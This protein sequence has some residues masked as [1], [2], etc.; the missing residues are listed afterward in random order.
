MTNYFKFTY[1]FIV[2]IFFS[3]LLNFSLQAEIKIINTKQSTKVIKLNNGKTNTCK[4]AQ[5]KIGKLKNKKISLLPDLYYNKSTK[6]FCISSKNKSSRILKTK[7]L[8]KNLSLN[9][10]N[11][12]GMLLTGSN[13]LNTILAYF[14][15]LAGYTTKLSLQELIEIYATLSRTSLDENKAVYTEILRIL[16]SLL[17]LS[18]PTPTPNSCPTAPRCTGNKHLNTSTCECACAAC[19]DG[20][21]PNDDSC[22]CS[23][24]PII[25]Y[26]P[27]PSCAVCTIAGCE[28]I[29]E[30]KY[31]EMCCDGG[32][33]THG[34]IQSF[35]GQHFADTDNDGTNDWSCGQFSRSCFSCSNNT[36]RCG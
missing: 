8:A 2:T 18:A 5:I 7:Y 17:A 33:C 24:P 36:R 28:N 3:I 12:R 10:R 34:D 29:M 31:E 15:E 32:N 35:I 25:I 19:P 26:P 6:S 22:T 27:I 20:Q 9:R 16:S 13:D 23:A 14:S 30:N 4:G 11:I 21:I 1:K